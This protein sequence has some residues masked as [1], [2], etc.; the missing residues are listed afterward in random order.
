MSG[1]DWLTAF[2]SRDP[3]Q[4]WNACAWVR[5]CWDR[6]VL[7]SLAAKRGAIDAAAS[8][9]PLGGALRPNSLQLDFALRKLA[10]AEGDA[11]FCNLFPTDD[12][13]DPRREAEAGH[14]VMSD[15]LIDRVNQETQWTCRCLVCD[16]S[17]RVKEVTGYH[18]PWYR[19]KPI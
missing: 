17:Y 15:E 16:A 11:C 8:G 5:R 2:L 19:W 7:R 10:F 13:F 9:V 4:I 1:E 3:Q 18:Y 14:L 6:P 12:L